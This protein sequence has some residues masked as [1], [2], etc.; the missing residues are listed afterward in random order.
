MPVKQYKNKAKPKA[1]SQAKSLG[2][3]DTANA[4]APSS[5]KVPQVPQQLQ[6]AV[7]DAY[8]DVLTIS[9]DALAQTVQQV[10]QRLYNRDFIQAF[11]T[12]SFR[13]AYTLRW[14]PSRALAY[15][16]IFH[17]L[18]LFPLGSG[19]GAAVLPGARVT[20]NR[21]V[22]VGGGGGAE[23]V[24]LAA[25]LRYRQDSSVPGAGLLSDLKVKVQ[26]AF[27]CTLLDIAD[28]S[29]V[30]R[31]LLSI[32]TAPPPV[33]Q[34]APQKLELASQPL[35]HPECFA[36]RFMKA[37]VLSM[38][39]EELR[40]SFQDVALVSVMFTLNELYST[41]MGA[42][43]TF[44]LGLTD[45]LTPGALLLVVDS[46]GSYSTVGIG[47]D[48]EKKY[49][50][51]W[52]LDHTLLESAIADGHGDVPR[53]EK[54]QGRDSQWFRLKGLRYPIELEDMRYQLHL[55]RRV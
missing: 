11:A 14:S 17:S 15:L 39:A 21:I 9:N 18:D 23:L 41:S 6:Q 28:W 35:A 44:L 3:K 52:L 10:K 34:Y 54:V 26:P 42:T 46:P 31:K 48:K 5:N 19:A 55:Y 8:K 20:R 40:I 4:S 49:P 16:N 2:L 27:D 53:W 47:S 13:E 22:C 25:Y 32:V 24:A 43:T 45:T 33:T 36:G 30:T 50:M 1:T 7:L 29:S 37:D 12:E 51:Q 38:D